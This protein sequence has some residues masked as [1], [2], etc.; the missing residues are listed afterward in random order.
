MS[1]DKNVPP[2]QTTD[3][4]AAALDSVKGSAGSAEIIKERSAK[5]GLP[6]RSFKQLLKDL[7][8]ALKNLSPPKEPNKIKN[9]ADLF[10]S[11]RTILTSLVIL[12]LS[13]LLF[14]IIYLELNRSFILI[15][16]FE[17]PESLREKGYTSNVVANKL[18]DQIN[19]ITATAKTKADRYKFTPS[20]YE[21]LPDVEV[22]EAKVSIKSIV[23]YVKE[24]FGFTPTRINGEILILDDQLHLTVRIVSAAGNLY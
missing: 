8:D 23:R 13:I 17:I 1:E 6:R 3:D 20:F 10:G 7:T 24:V 12:V 9:L 5:T 18:A 22:P 21:T 2:V 4:R 19:T 14:G 11:M 15:E 16:S